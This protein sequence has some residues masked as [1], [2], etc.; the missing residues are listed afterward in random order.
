M[1]NLII[2]S[3]LLALV[4]PVVGQN[5]EMRTRLLPSLTNVEV[6]HYLKRNDVIFIPVGPCEVHGAMPLDCEYVSPLAFCMKMAEEADGLVL[7]GL[8]YF[9]AGA[10]IGQGTV[11]TSN[12]ENIAYLKTIARSLLRQGF[13][14]QIY[15]TAHGPS[16]AFMEPFVFDFL[17]ET[18]VP[19]LY[20]EQSTIQN[21]Y[22]DNPDFNKIIYGSY[23]IVGRLD[24]IPLNFDHIDLPTDYN[25]EESMADLLNV[26]N[27]MPLNGQVQ[28]T[29]WYYN[30][31]F[32]HGG[33]PQNITTEERDQWA[34]EG[35]EI[36][37]QIVESMDMDK[38]IQSLKTHQDYIQDMV[39]KYGELL[40]E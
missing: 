9:Y 15:I 2:L 16:Y 5:T 14:T 38:I 1:K 21:E 39:D 23:S 17:N 36:I 12:E 24:D 26:F 10:T 35:E 25:I 30:S 8:Q 32:D 4:I 37:D 33:V 7:P 22:A 3:L 20:I 11:H 6:E 18:K 27:I 28:A 13:K 19:V 34:K 29:Q 40:P 31:Q